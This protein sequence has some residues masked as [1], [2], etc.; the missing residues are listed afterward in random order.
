MFVHVLVHVLVLHQ[1]PALFTVKRSGV[2]TPNFSQ[3]HF[4]AST[5][6]SIL[7]ESTDKVQMKV[8]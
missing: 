2:K 5:E 8:W 1:T 4:R 7:L 3:F 6:S